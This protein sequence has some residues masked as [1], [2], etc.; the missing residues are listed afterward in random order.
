MS[1]STKPQ[2][3]AFSLRSVEKQLAPAVKAWLDNVIVP[4]MVKQWI[5]P[6]TEEHGVKSSAKSHDAES[7]AGEAAATANNLPLGNHS[8]IG[9]GFPSAQ[10]VTQRRVALPGTG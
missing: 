6:R 3:S 7:E 5:A 9:N 10:G 1:Q 2:R 8:E 4:A